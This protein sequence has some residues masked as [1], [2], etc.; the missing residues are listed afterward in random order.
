MTN[1]QWL[2][3]QLIEMDDVKFTDREF[4]HTE[5]FNCETC[6]VKSLMCEPKK[7]KCWK[8]F[9]EWLK[10]EHKENGND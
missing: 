2:I 7:E 8:H 10:Q 1:R 9:I 6:P 5:E 3:W 4:Y